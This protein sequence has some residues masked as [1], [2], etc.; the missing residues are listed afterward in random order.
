MDTLAPFALIAAMLGAALASFLTVVVSRLGSG[1][2]VVRGRSRCPHCREKLVWFELV[3]I[4]S[5]LAQRGRC[6][7]CGASIPAWYFFAELVLAV[8][9]GLIAMASL[10]GKVLFPPF[11]LAGEAASPLLAGVTAL[12]YGVFLWF[13]VAISVYDIQR[14][15]IPLVLAGPLALLGAAGAVIGAVRS[16]DGGG[17]FV[18]FAA[19]L[20]AFLF[21]WMLWFFS[22]GRA[23]GRG[24]A[25]VAFAITLC[26][27]PLGGAVALLLGFWVGALYGI[28]ALALRRASWRTEIPFAP[29]LF[30]GALIALAASESFLFFRTVWYGP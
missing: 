23:M 9:F 30:T 21:F 18:H 16:G 26:L 13:A 3:P 17:L 4:A 24:D 14:R 7:S 29:F 28:L 19:A 2:T 6:R 1:E 8:G 12:Y 27:G 11:T 25:D 15:L 20:A 5:Y 10:S 22:R